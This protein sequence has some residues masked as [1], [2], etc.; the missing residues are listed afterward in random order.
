V[1]ATR[2]LARG[3]QFVANYTWSKSLDY[4]SQDTFASVD[5]PSN[6]LNVRQDYGPS[7]FD[8]RHRFTFSSVYELPFHANRVVQGWRLAGILTLQSGNPLNILAGNPAAGTGVS[9]FTGRASIRPDV[10]GSIP[11]VN[12]IITSGANAGLIQW[13]APNIVCDPR[14]VC[15]TGSIITIPVAV[16]GGNNV[17]HFG[18]LSRNA[19][20]GPS[21]KNVDL[22][23]TKSTKIT[24]RLQ[25]EFRVEAFDLFNH[26]NFGNPATRGA[27]STA[28]NLFGVINATR[29]PNG[30][31]GSARQLQFAVKFIF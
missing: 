9:S 26:P 5:R 3:L 28:G 7:D 31:S 19:V 13:I 16:V 22:S 23:L 8:A 21:F 24:E 11:V 18:N 10:S 20:I 6:S 25:N 27:V 15:P 14:G 12:Q 29:F 30:D 17:Y 1:S 4:S 2:R